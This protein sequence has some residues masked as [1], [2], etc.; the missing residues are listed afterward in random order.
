[1]CS[2]EPLTLFVVIKSLRR[3]KLTSIGQYLSD[4]IV[5][6]K[7]R[8]KIENWVQKDDKTAEFGL[9]G[10]EMNWDVSNG[11]LGVFW[12]FLVFQTFWKISWFSKKK[13][14][15]LFYGWKHF[16]FDFWNFLKN[17]WIYFFLLKFFSL[18]ISKNRTSRKFF[19]IDF[20]N[21][22]NSLKSSQ[23]FQ[24]FWTELKFFFPIFEKFEKKT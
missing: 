1:M 2:D 16:F 4:R 6:G 17:L 24:F 21:F 8:L 22:L 23:I 9:K 18:K 14:F 19:K 11:K 13:F 5:D 10:L 7:W 15:E 3:P 20:L 12:I